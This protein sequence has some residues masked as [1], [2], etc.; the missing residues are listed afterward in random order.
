MN[1]TSR[2]HRRKAGKRS[3]YK[4]QK[5]SEETESQN[6]VLAG[7]PDDGAIH[8]PPAVSMGQ[9]ALR[10]RRRAVLPA[11]LPPHRQ[12]ACSA[13]PPATGRF[14]TLAA[15]RPAGWA[16]TR[17]SQGSW[18]LTGIQK[19][20]PRDRRG[21]AEVTKASFSLTPGSP[22]RGPRPRHKP[23]EPKMRSDS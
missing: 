20:C 3:R 4:R 6:P 14:S 5:A 1:S 16:P 19:Q 13:R 23:S 17:G 8:R 12:A 9:T 21:A 22:T 7:K 18:H 10:S 11:S 15:P 2:K